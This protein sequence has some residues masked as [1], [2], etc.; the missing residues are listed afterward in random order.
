MWVK[1][2]PKIP[3]QLIINFPRPEKHPI[4]TIPIQK[5][6]NNGD[7]VTGTPVNITLDAKLENGD[8]NLNIDFDYTI[9]EVTKITNL[10]VYLA[11]ENLEIA[12]IIFNEG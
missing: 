9:P 12:E 5:N 6:L 4:Y 2:L 1:N 7:Q 11:T 3:S 8:Y 10:T